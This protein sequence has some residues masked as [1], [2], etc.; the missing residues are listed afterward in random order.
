[1]RY[2]EIV[3]PS[4]RHIA[5]DTGPREAAAEE[6]RTREMKTVGAWAIPNSPGS[7]TLISQ[8]SRRPHLSPRRSQ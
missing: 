5:A 1:M 8:P 7:Q 3:K 6:R 2:R 4:A